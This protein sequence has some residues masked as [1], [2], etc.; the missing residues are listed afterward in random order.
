M[1]KQQIG[2]VDLALGMAE[3][4]FAAPAMDQERSQAMAEEPGMLM[5]SDP[6]HPG[7]LSLIR[8]NPTVYGPTR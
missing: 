3:A 4:T 8:F 6:K 1:S 2:E 7:R 5:V